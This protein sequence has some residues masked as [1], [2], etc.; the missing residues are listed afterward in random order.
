MAEEGM[1]RTSGCVSSSTSTFTNIPGR[2]L[3]S[4]FA[5]VPWTSTLRVASSTRN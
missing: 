2:S 5:T 3:C 4:G 1:A